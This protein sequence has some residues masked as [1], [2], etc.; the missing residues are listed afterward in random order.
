MVTRRDRSYVR[1]Q[2]GD[3]LFREAFADRNR[4]VFLGAASLV[5][6]QD[7]P[8]RHV[9]QRGWNSRMMILTALGTRCRRSSPWRTRSSC[10]FTA[11][12]ASRRIARMPPAAR[13]RPARHRR[14]RYAC[15]VRADLA[16]DPQRA[17]QADQPP[18]ALSSSAD[19]P[20]STVF[21]RR[22]MKPSWSIASG[23][24]TVIGTPPS[25]RQL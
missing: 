6:F 10:R 14:D 18:N 13:P 17:P 20:G 3:R 24:P 1:Q 5:E 11:P 8:V 9:Q 4:R 22:A 7:A 21:Q 12:A 25:Q 15:D 16:H 23:A 19:Q 2:A